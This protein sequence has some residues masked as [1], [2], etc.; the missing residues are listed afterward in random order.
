[1]SIR[2]DTMPSSPIAQARRNR[3]APFAPSTW[4]E[5]QSASL[6][7]N[8]LANRLRRSWSGSLAEIL[9]IEDE[10]VIGDQARVPTSLPRAQ[11]VEVRATVFEQ[12]D[13]LAVKDDALDRKARHRGADQREVLGPIPPGAR[14]Q[15]HDAVLAPRDDPI[16]IRLHLVNPFGAGRDLVSRD[17]LTGTDEALRLSRSRARMVRHGATFTVTADEFPDEN[18]KGGAAH[19]RRP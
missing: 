6:P 10:K 12:A 11:G 1:M 4:L 19:R 8:R 9:A 16:T 15:V 18:E 13:G 14:P 3:A 5:N 2:F 17:R 7:L